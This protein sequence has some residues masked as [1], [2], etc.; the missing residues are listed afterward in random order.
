MA[1]KRR[2][3]ALLV[4]RCV[5]TTAAAAAL[6]RADPPRPPHSALSL[7]YKGF[8]S[9]D[10][11][12]AF[13]GEGKRKSTDVSVSV[14]VNGDQTSVSVSVGPTHSAPKGAKRGV[15]RPASGGKGAG[16]GGSSSGGG[17]AKRKLAPARCWQPGDRARHKMSGDLG[18]VRVVTANPDDG[19]IKIKV[20]GMRLQ[21]AANFDRVAA[22]GAAVVVLLD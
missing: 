11:A 9:E 2:S 19:A 20:G 14:N 17:G 8:S 13:L 7:Q 5:V 4:Q 12:R 18:T 10:A 15:K 3:R 1:Q 16:G 6:L 22:E 21:S